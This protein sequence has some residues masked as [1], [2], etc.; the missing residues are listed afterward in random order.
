MEDLFKKY[1]ERFENLQWL[2]SHISD[3]SL[4]QL[5]TF[6]HECS[7]HKLTKSAILAL[8]N[9]CIKAS[10]PDE[11]FRAVDLLNSEIFGHEDKTKVS[12]YLDQI[13]RPA[14]ED[15]L[16]RTNVLFH[17]YGWLYGGAERAIS[18]LIN[19][20]NETF[21]I[22]LVVFSPVENNTY[23]LHSNID[24]MEIK[25][26]LDKVKRLYKLICLLCPEVF[27][28]NNNSIPEL[29][30][31]YEWLENESIKTIA[32]N[33]EFYFYMHQNEILCELTPAKNYYLAKADA[34][35]F[36]TSFSTNA[37]SLVNGNGATIPNA[38]SFKVEE[39]TNFKRDSKKILAV[40]RFNDIIKRVDLLLEVFAEVIK[41]VPDA[42]LTIVGP[43]NMDLV[44]S[45]TG[46]T[47]EKLLN[48]L[49][50]ASNK[51]HFVGN[52][53]DVT[54]W[55]KNS[56]LLVM[57]SNN[58]GFGMVL[59]EAGAFGLP[60]IA[61]AIPG[62]EDIIIDGVNGYL[63]PRCV[64]KMA[65]KVILLLQSNKLREEM[66]TAAL[67][68]VK[69]FEAERI[70]SLWIT[71]INGLLQREDKGTIEKF[72]KENFQKEPEDNS[73]FAELVMKEYENS[74]SNILKME[75]YR[76]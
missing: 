1:I 15:G 71:L 18:Q 10:T 63:V 49:H 36:L 29:L 69:R 58:E 6:Y 33:H 37:Y 20:M 70:G 24:F 23:F 65:E 14:I 35:V 32:Y 66:S 28:G 46:D 41:K 51:V 30:P 55:Y 9:I 68:Y 34:A 48:K 75:K 74:L 8:R 54:K 2:E 31:I 4:D 17:L 67:Q 72:L 57:T 11:R 25:S 44:I 64:E 62:L 22:Y 45:N 56:D 47:V 38:L 13:I 19:Q 43:Y 61:F 12:K 53:T 59:S 5:I 7:Y 73:L 3:Q 21:H 27:V 16:K 42:E 50:L 76:L 26:D 60:C 52:Q 39:N 40:G